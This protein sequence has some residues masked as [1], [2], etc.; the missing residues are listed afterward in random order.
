MPKFDLEHFYTLY[1]Q[2]NGVVI[3]DSREAAEAIKA[4]WLEVVPVDGPFEH[5]RSEKSLILAARRAVGILRDVCHEDQQIAGKH[6]LDSV[7]RQLEDALAVIVN[8]SSN[9]K[10]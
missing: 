3:Y 4:R 7:A 8:P 5:S 6:N 2:D 1:N 9:S 10:S